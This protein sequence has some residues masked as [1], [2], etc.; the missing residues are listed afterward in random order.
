MFVP[1]PQQKKIIDHLDGHA[2]VVAGP[3]SGKTVTLIAHVKKLVMES[4]VSPDSMWVMAFNRDISAKLKDSIQRELGGKSPQTT[5]QSAECDQN[6]GTC[7][8]SNACTHKQL[9]QEAE[10]PR[11][12][13]MPAG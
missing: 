7:F 8:A 2:F 13:K 12:S 11:R 4:I 3:G 5:T 10:G 9:L 1:T 6:G